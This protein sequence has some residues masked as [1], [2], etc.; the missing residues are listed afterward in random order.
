MAESSGA[1]EHYSL[2]LFENKH[3]DTETKCLNCEE[4]EAQ[5]REVLSELNSAQLIIKLLQ[6]ELSTTLGTERI[7]IVGTESCLVLKEVN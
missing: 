1:C 6:R 7:G 2:D 5:L 4:L 3:I